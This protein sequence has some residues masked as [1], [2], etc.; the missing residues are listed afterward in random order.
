[1][2]KARHQKGNAADA[3]AAF[4]AYKQTNDARLTEIERRGHADPVIDDKLARIDK[5]LEALSLKSAR[6]ELGGSEEPADT[7]HSQSWQR[8]LRAGDE[9]GL[10]RLD[11]K[12]LNAGTDDQGGYVAPPELDQL[13][14]SRL[15]AGSP[16]RQ[17]ASVR[18]TSA[19][20]FRKPIGLGVEA[21]WAGETE[22]RPET[23]TDGLSL[24][25]FP[26][27]ELYAL[28]AATQTLL[29]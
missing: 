28:P 3:L 13:I 25:E 6:A 19:G 21:R 9:S 12:S 16:M 17:I 1:M 5:R 22:A 27:G 10:A 11:V 26:A 2:A 8:Y 29:D 23:Q 14:E 20:V 24:V 15:L 18:Q 7:E 4:E